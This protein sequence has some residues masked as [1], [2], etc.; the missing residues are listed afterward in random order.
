MRTLC[1][2]LITVTGCATAG[3]EP[4]ARSIDAR[5]TPD[6]RPL[7]FPPDA[8]ID[9]SVRPDIDAST[10]IDAG[11]IDVADIDAAPVVP[12]AGIPDAAPPDAYQCSTQILQLLGN[13]D[14]E[15]GHT[16]WTETTK[17]S[18]IL[19]NNASSPPI[20]AESGT[21]LAWMGSAVSYQDYLF[22]TLTV[23]A[24]VTALR[25]KGYYVVG[26]N[27]TGA[28]AFDTANLQI[29]VGST[30]TSLHTF[31]NLDDNGSSAW[32]SFSY[33]ISSPFAGQAIK[34]QITS[35][36][37]YSNVTNFFFDNLRLEATVCR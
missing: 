36:N 20:S 27:E 3:G 17:F 23:P 30:L 22:Q 37:D 16:I 32:R 14:F 19:L 5:Q 24:D 35:S 7:Q 6:A 1:L 8:D 28:A 10:D 29:Y 13:P 11:S 9:G 33:A 4:D 26:T 12:D 2:A 31:S 15:Q 34:F 25:I 21:W 18:G